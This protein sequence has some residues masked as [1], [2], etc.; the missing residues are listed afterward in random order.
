MNYGKKILHMCT[1]RALPKTRKW[2]LGPPEIQENSEGIW[3]GCGKWKNAKKSFPS[4]ERKDKGIFEM[5]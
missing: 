4:H 5:V 2:V 1:N 3:K